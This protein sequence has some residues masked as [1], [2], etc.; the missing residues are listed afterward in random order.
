MC[1]GAIILARLPRLVYGCRDPRVGAVG[2]IYDFSQDDRF[3]HRV[4][5]TEGVLAEE[6]SS[7]LSGFF[8]ELREQKKQQKRQS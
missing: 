2:S 4:E 3:N 6:C 7:L 8:R 5:V 1:M